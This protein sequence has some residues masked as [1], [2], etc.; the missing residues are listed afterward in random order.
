[1][2]KNSVLEKKMF[3]Q[4]ELWKQSG[5]TMA[6]FARKLG[7]HKDAFRYW[8]NKKKFTD[9]IAKQQEYS[10]VNLQ[11]STHSPNTGEFSGI[12]SAA[13][14]HIVLTFPSGLR[15]EIFG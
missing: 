4:V 12:S 14:S 13:T 15:L 9:T 10:F 5:M 6:D 1:M 8:V 3:T 11:A 7:I 2:A